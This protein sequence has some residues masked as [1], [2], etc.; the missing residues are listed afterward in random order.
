MQ[1]CMAT[2]MK[3]R[4]KSYRVRQSSEATAL[5]QTSAV[6]HRLQGSIWPPLLH[7]VPPFA[8]ERPA[9]WSKILAVQHYLKDVDWVMWLDA[10][11][12]VTN[13]G[14]SIPTTLQI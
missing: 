11:T 9:S 3:T 1:R 7:A 8:D 10:D 6:L 5:Q 2:R 13:P 4:A 14:Q 12:I